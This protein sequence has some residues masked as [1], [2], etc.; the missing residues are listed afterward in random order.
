MALLGEMHFMPSTVD[1]WFNL[2]R[3][4]G[5]AYAAQESWVQNDTIKQNILFGAPYDGDRYQKGLPHFMCLISNSEIDQQLPS[6][7]PMCLGTRS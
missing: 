2:P 7:L 5:V 1:S 3:G 4:G 6:H